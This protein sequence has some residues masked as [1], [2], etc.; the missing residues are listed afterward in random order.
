MLQL[1]GRLYVAAASERSIIYS[2]K[3]SNEEDVDFII[4]LESL[5]SWLTGLLMSANLVT[6]L[7]NRH[8]IR[9]QSYQHI[10]K[11]L[12]YYLKWITENRNKY[13]MISIYAS[14]LVS[15]FHLIHST[16]MMI[17]LSS[18]HNEL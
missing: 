18:F 12:S 9:E 15:Q 6:H 4:D 14:L 3:I 16:V 7:N 11:R 5:S 1:E 17:S 13:P 10:E 8:D 2:K